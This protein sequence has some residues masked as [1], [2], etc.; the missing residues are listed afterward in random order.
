VNIFA[1]DADPIRAAEMACD[2]HVVKMA[3]ETAQMLSTVCRLHGVNVG[4]KVSH[5]NHPCTK[6]A[7]TTQENFRWLVEHGLGLC[8]EYTYRYGKVHAA[9]TVIRE[10]HQACLSVEFTEKELQPFAKCMP[11]EFFDEDPVQAYRR[12]YIGAKSRFARWR[13]NR[14]EPEW[15]TAGRIKQIG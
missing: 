12:F 9:A 13:R 14:P 7:G 4:Y 6:W 15:Y 10:V 11:D 5:V 2:Q 3:T 1:L 8:G